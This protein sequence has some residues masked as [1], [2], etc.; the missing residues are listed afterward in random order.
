[1]VCWICYMSMS[2]LSLQ[3]RGT[4][5][6][7]IL[8]D[9]YTYGQDIEDYINSR[10]HWSNYVLYQCSKV[11]LLIY[12]NF[13][14][15]RG[16][17][18][19]QLHAM[20]RGMLTHPLHNSDP[21]INNVITMLRGM[22]THPDSVG[23]GDDSGADDGA[24]GAEKHLVHL[25]QVADCCWAEISKRNKHLVLEQDDDAHD[26]DVDDEDDSVGNG[27]DGGADDGA[28]GAEKQLV[29]LAQVADCRLADWFHCHCS[30]ENLQFFSKLLLSPL[31]SPLAP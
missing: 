16:M 28:E 12:C 30:N 3:L 9:L 26:G 17:F 6:Q 23:N 21:E 24:E 4:S 11:S 20:L 29:H 15:L 10:L 7:P 13:T 25:A 27:D 2:V 5:A 18:T 31:L 14:M 8:I 19:H 1:L 22:I